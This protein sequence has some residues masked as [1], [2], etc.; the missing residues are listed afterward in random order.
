MIDTKPYSYNKL[1]LD[2]SFKHQIYLQQ[3]IK[4]G[5]NRMQFYCILVAVPLKYKKHQDI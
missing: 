3:Y 2:A 5:C 4:R 1:C